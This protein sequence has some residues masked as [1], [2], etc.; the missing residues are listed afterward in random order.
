[1]TLK[2]FGAL[3]LAGAMM[4]GTLG[5]MSPT[6]AKADTSA[7]TYTMTV[8][9]DMDIQNS[10]WNSLGNIEITGSIDEAKTVTVTAATANNFALTS[11]AG[12][13]V[14]YTLKKAEADT[15][16]TTSF[17]F[18]AASINAGG[19]S[20]TIGVDVA[21]FSEKAAGTY[22]DTITFTGTMSTG[23]MSEGSLMEA[24]A[25]FN[26]GYCLVMYSS[27]NSTYMDYA[28]TGQWTSVIQN[29][30][31]KPSHVW[32]YL[33]NDEGNIVAYEYPF[34]TFKQNGKKPNSYGSNVTAAPISYDTEWEITDNTGLK[35]NPSSGALYSSTSSNFYYD[36]LEKYSDG[37]MLVSYVYTKD[38][39][40]SGKTFTRDRNMYYLIPY[41]LAN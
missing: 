41:K 28:T 39:N 35:G 17:E 23:T 6:Q 29:G 24:M 38:L 25:A 18:D 9:G 10:G 36:V 22:T 5:V 27:S 31:V 26:G 7:N 1:M 12:E 20:Q 4:T 34:D 15:A 33:K 37:T 8:P 3:L 11:E 21:D 14:S 13:S 40:V 19:A 32:Y 2:K 16:A 30:T